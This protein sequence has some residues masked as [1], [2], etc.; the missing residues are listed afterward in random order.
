MAEGLP[1]GPTIVRRQFGHCVWDIRDDYLSLLEEVAPPAW[2][3]LAENPAAALVKENDGRQ[4]WRVR[5][6]VGDVFAK[7][8][9]ADDIPAR[10]KRWLRGPVCLSEWRA[11]EY[12]SRY[13]LPTVQPIARAYTCSPRHGA[14]CLLLTRAVPDAVPLNE[15]WSQLD[16]MADAAR[17]RRCANRLIAA[18]ADLIATAHQSGFRHV[19]LH[20]G[21]L[22][23]VDGSP[24]DQPPRVIF[25][26]LHG[27]CT[28]RA[29]SD[30]AVVRNLAQLNQW[31]RRHASL[32]QRIRFL[33]RY[34]NARIAMQDRSPHARPLG[35]SFHDLVA[36]LDR[37]AD[38][39]ARELYAQRDRRTLR[40]NK[41]FARVRLPGG[42]RGHVFLCAKHAG[43]ESRAS[44]IVFD[45]KQWE[46]WLADPLRWMHAHEPWQMLKDSHT[47]MV[48][49]RSLPVGPE[50]LPVI[51]KRPRAR[52]WARRLSSLFRESRNLRTWRRG[53]A[54]I[55]R[56]LPTAR[57]LAVLERRRFGLRTDSLLITE[58]LPDAHDLDAVIA[59]ELTRLSPRALYRSKR[60]LIESLCALVKRMDARGF[61]HRDLKASNIMIQWDPAFA[62][63][64]RLSL[65]D[66]DG[67]RP[68][69]GLPASPTRYAW[70]AIARL[71]V[72]LE[73]CRAVSRTDRLRFL[74][75]FLDGWGRDGE[76]WK[77]AWRRV[78]TLADRTRRKH[79][80][81]QAWKL[82]HYGRT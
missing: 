68:Q 75:R 66:L 50:P 70:R 62:T 57:P 41:Y 55:H 30:L 74:Q 47:A 9:V 46:A 5:T 36:A 48:C 22:L 25:V 16:H 79:E 32:T 72:S 19:D 44:S 64:P 42:W 24:T 10:F 81:H 76:D 8:Y 6:S 31:F 73:H 17:R 1:S 18:V 7:V 40:T 23:V 77:S 33:R 65:V 58:A 20:A 71:S 34:V 29:V 28:G 38:E 27:V 51:C 54:L 60:L 53:Y 43:A 80:Q 21:N 82:R 12:A 35:L 13:G 11:A 45:R 4:V 69:R 67:L 26:D 56:D 3:N 49:R 52:T 39:H 78:E 63:R 15:Y 61:A 59:T 14:Q 37:R 2:R